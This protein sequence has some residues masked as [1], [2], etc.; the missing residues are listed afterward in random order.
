M[1][2]S[3]VHRRHHANSDAHRRFGNGQLIGSVV[4]ARQPDWP[5][6]KPRRLMDWGNQLRRRGAPPDPLS[7]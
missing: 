1:G 6:R 7:R 5:P 4:G 2:L 3:V